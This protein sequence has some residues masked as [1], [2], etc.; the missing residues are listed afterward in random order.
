MKNKPTLDDLFQSK[1]LDLPNEDFWNGFQDRVKGRTMAALS[2]QTKTAKVR[3]AGIYSVVPV[4]VMAMVGWSALQLQIGTRTSSKVASLETP[5]NVG[6]NVQVELSAVLGDEAVIE[7][8]G[9]VQ[10]AQLE[11]FDS[12]ANARIQLA[13]GGDRFNHH[14]LS[15]GQNSGTHSNYTF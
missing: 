5:A 9:V 8:E 15:L 3:R 7:R 14:T 10:L 2:Q 6:L 12:F 4:M 13:G 1:K 11:S